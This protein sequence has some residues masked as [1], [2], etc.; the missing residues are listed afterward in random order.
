MSDNSASIESLKDKKLTPYERWEEEIKQAEL[1]LKDFHNRG[2][3]V[4]RRFLDERDMLDSS[5]KWFNIYYANTNIMESALYAQLPKPS[6]SRRFKDYDDDVA[7]VAGTI[8]QRSI[9]QDLDDPR[10]AFDS[11][12][13]SCV[14]DRLI[15][16][17]AAAWLRLETDTEDVPYE[18]ATGD[19]FH[20]ED[21]T[22]KPPEPLKK[23][24]DQ[25]VCID[26]VYWQDFIWSP[27][28]TWEERRWVGRKA[29]MSRDALVKRFGEK[30]GNEVSLDFNPTLPPNHG[31]TPGTTPKHMAI[32]QAIVYEIWDR[33]SRKVI[34][35]SKG[36]KE[37]LD[38]KDDPLKLV[39]FEPC[40]RPMLANITTSNTVPRPDYY[41]IQD[42]YQE[43]DTINNRVSMLLQACKVVGVYDQS[44]SGVSRMLTEGF[45]NQ[46]IPVDNWAMFAEKGG[47]KGQ[48]DWLPLD[49]VVD[50]LTQLITNRDLIKAQIYEL[51]GIS[52]IVRGASKASETLGAQEI[53][54]KFASIAIKKRQDEVARFAADLLRLKAEIQVKHFDDEFLLKNSNIVA[55]GADNVKLIEPALALLHADEG[56]EWRIQ[57][58]A[59]SIAQADYAMEKADRIEFLTAVS[60]YLEKAAGMFQAVPGSASFL[61]GML[62]WAVAGF[63]NA[64][65]IEGM[66]DKE[67]DA[68][69]KAPP[70]EP[71]PDPEE[72]KMALEKQKVEGK[73]AADAQKAQLDKQKGEQ[74]IALKERMGQME[75]RMKEMELQFKV[76]ELELKEK[77]ANMDMNFAAAEAAQKQR[78][79]LMESQMSLD[80][81]AQEH[82][83]NLEQQKESHA[84]ESEQAH[85]DHELSMEQTKEQGK[86]KTQVMKQ[87]AA[88]KPK[89]KPAGGKK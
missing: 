13:R 38:T 84:M 11:T 46:L 47:L 16:G 66:L 54:S 4:N 59:D 26:Y 79:T 29:Y 7:R 87:Q 85:E 49:V 9:T 20:P 88:A 36:Y 44:A 14:Q 32:K 81:Q 39:G 65:E 69:S 5:N 86:V 35:F 60:G 45:D 77:E 51:T 31:S 76:K 6:V 75:M 43:L 67:L 12:M 56:F 64:S 28:R 25:R 63:R 78:T 72:Q 42:Q 23:I 53:K 74:E 24:T 18:E 40:P 61:V 58:T 19:T 82:A 30:I 70:P 21:E 55:T 52:D 41:M 37:I 3:K 80:T 71:P 57:V 1:E 33:E 22:D 48:V 34:W 83:M 73:M 27:C 8:I 2:R 17:L 89:P 50:A 62:K 68:I 10:D 15:P